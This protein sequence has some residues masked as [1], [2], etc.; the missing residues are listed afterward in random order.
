MCLDEQQE[1][2]LF[3]YLLAGRAKAPAATEGADGATPE[4]EAPAPDA[5]P[6][7]LSDPAIDPELAISQ[8]ATRDVLQAEADGASAE[9]EKDMFQAA[10]VMK[11]GG[12]TLGSFCMHGDVLLQWSKSFDTRRS[13]WRVLA[14][15]SRLAGEKGATEQQF[16]AAGALGQGCLAPGRV[17]GPRPGQLWTRGPLRVPRAHSLCP[18]GRLCLRS[19]PVRGH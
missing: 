8:E 3:P 1:A 5:L 12:K 16:E 10:L 17:V 15:A 19:W 18:S 9:L 7:A 13:P 6:P 4:A 11:V 2:V 14:T